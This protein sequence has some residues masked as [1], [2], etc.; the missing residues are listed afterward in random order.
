M[1]IHG[2]NLIVMKN[3]VAMAAARSCDVNV[4]C[5]SIEISSPL[6]SRW[7]EYISGRCSWDV[8]TSHLVTD[9]IS[10]IGIVGG[11]VTLKLTVMPPVVFPFDGVVSNVVA[12]TILVTMYDAIV[13]DSIQERFLA[14][15]NRGEQTP[16]YYTRWIG[17]EDY[18]SPKNGN[19]YEQGNNIYEWI[20]G[21]LQAIQ[22]PSIS[23]TEICKRYKVSGN[24][25]NL[26][27]GAFSFQGCGPLE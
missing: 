17:G 24:V 2:R 10:D 4:Q 11:M 15:I 25:N 12:Q 16:Y 3:G 21:S 26:A 8:S 22:L 5:E 18:M 13:Y 19:I 20:D 6:S 1:I 27:N 14:R 7:R 9:P 23:G